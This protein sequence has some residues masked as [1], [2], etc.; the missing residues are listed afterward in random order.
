MSRC[1]RRM[2]QQRC[3][4]VTRRRILLAS[5]SIRQRPAAPPLAPT[6]I[7]SSSARQRCRPRPPLP[8]PIPPQRTSRRRSRLARR[9]PRQRRKLRRPE[10]PAAV[11]PA[12]RPLLRL[13]RARPTGRRPCLLRRRLAAA[14]AARRRGLGA[15]RRKRGRAAAR[16]SSE[17]RRRG[18]G[19]GNSTAGGEHRRRTAGRLA[20][21][22]GRRAEFRPPMRDVRGDWPGMRY[23]A[24]ARTAAAGRRLPA[25][26]VWSGRGRGV[27]AAARDPAAAACRGAVERVFPYTDKF[28]YTG[29]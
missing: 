29:E 20:G 1:I 28:R 22:G 12:L 25:A 9:R 2:K 3:R 7:S 5:L 15:F 17:G 21:A 16:R 11:L 4:H 26:R 23:V 8:R 18:C 27:L 6:R 24:R 19:H 10:A 14:R 13:P